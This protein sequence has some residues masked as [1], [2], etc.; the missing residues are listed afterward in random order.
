MD[1][2]TSIYLE[3][4]SLAPFTTFIYVIG[5]NKDFEFF[6]KVCFELEISM[7]LNNSKGINHG[8]Y[9]INFKNGDEFV[10]NWPLV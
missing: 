6:A 3:Q 10:F 2:G 8:S 1:D 4:V 7:N 5:P 9:K